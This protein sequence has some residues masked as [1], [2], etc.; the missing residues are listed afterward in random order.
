MHAVLGI[1]LQAVG[2]VIILDEF[3]DTRWAV[4]AFG[5]SIFGQVH[6]D[7]DGGILQCQ[8]GRLLLFVVP[9]PGVE[10]DD[11]LRGRIRAAVRTELSPRHVPDRIDAI[12]EPFAHTMDYNHFWYEE[13]SGNGG[14][15]PRCGIPDAFGS[16]QAWA[17]ARWPAGGWKSSA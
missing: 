1:D 15:F 5:S 12:A 10:L 11:G 6:A 8:V 3:V 16:W 13:G 7:R 4:T 14:S 9:R 2:A 17:V